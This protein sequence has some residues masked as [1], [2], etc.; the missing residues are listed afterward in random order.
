M[1]TINHF[2][3][4][5]IVMVFMLIF[6]KQSSAEASSVIDFKGET[7]ILID[8]DTG[9]V[10][11]EKEPDKQMYPASTTK[12]LTAILLIE[13]GT[14]SDITTTSKNA[15]YQIGSSLYL[16]EG[17]DIL[18]E[19]LLYGVMLRSGNDA[20]TVAAEYVAGTVED[21]TVLMNEKAA[22]LGAHNT[23]FVNPHGLH[24]DDHYTTARDLALI[25]AYSMQNEVFREVVGTPTKFI[26]W[27]SEEWDRQLD[28]GNRLLNRYSGADGIKTG[29]TSRSGRTLVASATKDGMRLIAVSLNSSHTFEDAIALFDY[30]FENFRRETILSNNQTL[31]QAQVKFG[32]RVPLLN[33]GELFYTKYINEDLNVEFRP[34][35]NTLTAPI[36]KGI[37]AGT[38]EVWVN[39]ELVQ[40]LPLIA[41]ADID[42]KLYT[43]WWFYGLIIMTIYIPFRLHIAR[44]RRRRVNRLV[45]RKGYYDRSY[46]DYQ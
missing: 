41:A 31:V 5:F 33:S 35:L 16:D 4:L 19:D 40:S 29:Y 46:M 17:E 44:K 36:E 22:K 28:N 7:G 24:H 18:I 13:K 38:V 26:P 14:L 25:S 21:F 32:G 6:S 23:N 1:S 3:I 10:L 12:I 11:W 42:R 45:R 30:G 37:L 27:P 2:R 39:N 9:Q 8:A 15:R 20:A 34:V 43:H